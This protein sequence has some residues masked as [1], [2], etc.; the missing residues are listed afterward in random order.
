MASESKISWTGPTLNPG[1]YGCERISPACRN[2]YA[3]RMAYRQ[4]KMGNYPPEITRLGER[5]VE[6]TGKVVVNEARIKPAFK[7]LPKRKPTRVFVTSMADLFHRDVPFGFIDKVMGEIRAR[8]HLTFQVLTKRPG[9]ALSWSQSA[10][11]RLLPGNVWMGATVEDQRRAEER[12][13]LLL[14][15]PARVRFLSCEP[16]L[17][18]LNL[19]A[20]LSDAG[21]F[22]EESPIHW[23]ICGGESGGR[24][25]QTFSGWVY[26]LKRQCEI[27]RVAFFM[28]QLGSVWAKA[29]DCKDS[30]GGDITEFP[31]DLQVRQFPE[32]TH[33]S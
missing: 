32:V 33:G 15:I 4:V 3:M 14:Q 23:V 19:S 1:I 6:W 13:P 10:A 29:W 22:G 27:A 8:P 20:W 31:A 11:W 24:A 21:L 17:S 16:L 12:I 7:A 5:G 26:D 9:Q 2:C 25:R 30:K 28:K 18:Q